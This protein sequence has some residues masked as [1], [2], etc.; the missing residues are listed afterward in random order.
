MA[1]GTVLSS[2]FG[3]GPGSR[4]R[5]V[6]GSAAGSQPA[7]AQA[8]GTTSSQVAAAQR[9]GG[10]DPAA[11]PGAA[12]NTGNQ[13]EIDAAR[14]FFESLFPGSS[15]SPDELFAKSDELGRQGITVLRNA[16]GTTAKI[17]LA[18]GAVIDVIGGAEAGRNIRQ[19]MDT[20]VFLDLE[21]NQVPGP[22]G[23][24][25]G[26]SPSSSTRGATTSS[27]TPG[28]SPGEKVVREGSVVVGK[29]KPRPNPLDPPTSTGLSS[30]YD[31]A[32]RERRRSELGGRQGTVLGG[33]GGGS[34][35]TRKPTLLGR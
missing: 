33:F 19:F 9:R 17:R 26:T 27:S 13:S 4:E 29:A 34:P 25:G 8:Q 18:S 6:V 31:A 21:G 28:G 30:A 7:S 2:F 1:L 14:A 23:G 5:H 10:A 11:S 24:A 35:T 12:T 20:G 16:A 22:T 15:L 32:L 3:R